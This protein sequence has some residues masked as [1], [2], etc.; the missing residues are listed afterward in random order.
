MKIAG[1]YPCDVKLDPK[2]QHAVSEP[3][4]LEMIL[5]MAKDAGHEVELFIPMEE[6]GGEFIG[7]TE[8]EMIEN[9]VKF[10]PD[11]AAFSMFTCQYPMGQRIA[12]ELKDQLG[13]RVINVAGNRYVTYLSSQNEIDSNFDFAKGNLCSA[14]SQNNNIL[15][16][17]EMQMQKLYC[18]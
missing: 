8:S 10:D 16:N 1:I 7:M 18:Q 13:D 15:D 12:R 6:R 9:I 3:Y 2:V 11:V 17:E 5:A 4:G 14:L